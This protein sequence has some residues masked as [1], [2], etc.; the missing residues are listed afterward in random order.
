MRR[1]IKRFFGRMF[2]PWQRVFHHSFKQY[3]ADQREKKRMHFQHLGPDSL[4]LDIGGFEGNWAHDMHARYGCHIHVFEPHPKFAAKIAERFKGNNK[5]TVHDF[6]IGSQNGTLELTDDGDASS[7][8][9]AR[10]KSAIQGHVM[11]V[12]D[13]FANHNLPKIDLIKVNIEGGEYDLLPAL[14]E[15][16]IVA[17]T[18]VLQIQFHLYQE[19]DIAARDK[20]NAGLAQTHQPEWSYPFVWEQWKRR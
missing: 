4:V 14:L 9:S 7:A 15:L 11:A 19:G 6:A 8:L 10:R 1:K 20:I 5:I 12:A 13:F 18:E 3:Q 16:G 2:H 17:R